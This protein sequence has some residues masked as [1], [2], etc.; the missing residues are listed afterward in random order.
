MRITVPVDLEHYKM[1]NQKAKMLLLGGWQFG[2]IK[3]EIRI[4]WRWVLQKIGVCVCVWGVNSSSTPP[5]LPPG[6]KMVRRIVSEED[7][8]M[9]KN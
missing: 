4:I 1:T 2:L 7:R 8:K 5:S 3:R 9:K 6:L